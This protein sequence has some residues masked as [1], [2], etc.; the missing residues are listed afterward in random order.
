[1]PLPIKEEE[2]EIIT[3][4]VYALYAKHGFDGI[5]MDE[6]SSQS[7]ISKATLYRYYT[8]KEDIVR[9]MAKFLIDHLDSVQFSAIEEIGDT[10][11]SLR[12]FYTKSVL[13][14]ALAGSE[15]LTDLKHKFPD[16]YEE[17]FK[18][19]EAM[20]KRYTNFFSQAVEK[21]FFRNL[22]FALVSKQFGNMLPTIINMNYLE[23]HRLS[24]TEALREYFRMFLCQILNT[25]Y[26][27]V[28]DQ[29]ETYSFVPALAELSINDFFIDSI[30]R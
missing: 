15:F 3:R 18:A 1:M 16:S 7:G 17:C 22:P 24:L 25:E 30:R 23:Q 29:E 13:I 9:G 19:M 5:S 4:K 11:D 6:I 2:L 28:T 8:S 10:M 21:G 20:Q 12:E 14:T 27:C 26:L